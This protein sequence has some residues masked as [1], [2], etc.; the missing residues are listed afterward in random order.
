MSK[1]TRV[2]IV[3]SHPVQYFS[4]LFDLL[5]ERGRVAV[6]VLYG[7]DA[8]LRPQWDPGFGVEHR[9]DLDLV[10]H[11]KHVFAT[12][13]EARSLRN[14]L[15]GMFRTVRFVRTS[16]V[17]VIHGYVGA[18]T[19]TVLLAC[20]L[21]RKRYFLRSDTS[22]RSTYHVWDPREFWPRLV[23]RRSCGALAAGQRNAAVATSLGAPSATVAPFAVD[24]RRFREAAETVCASDIA[25]VAFVGKFRPTKRPHDVVEAARRLPAVKF[26]MVGEGPLGDELR[27]AAQGLPNINFVGFVNQTRMPLVLASADLLVLPSQ[28]EPWGLVVNEAMA[29][30]LVPVVSE[31]VGCA[32][33]L[34][35][36]LGETFP[37]GDVEALCRAIERGLATAR[38]RETPAR[39]RDRVDLYSMEACAQAYERALAETPV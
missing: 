19:F 21:F 32:P 30:G 1:P 23:Y 25:T 33:D 18:L 34:V 37:T 3:V 20:W 13:G 12:C 16:D 2:G 11:H 14:A 9:W 5:H 15:R 36:G 29:C 35:T 38:A 6:N 8:G 17:L 7:N 22:V 39:L 26:L 24:N 31:A 10:A 27:A 4:P 28:Y